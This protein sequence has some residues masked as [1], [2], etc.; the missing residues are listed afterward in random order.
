MR[1]QE[2]RRDP[3]CIDGLGV[4]FWKETDNPAYQKFLS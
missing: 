4:P 3:I 1:I 2:S